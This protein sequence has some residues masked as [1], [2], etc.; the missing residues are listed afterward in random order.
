LL[1]PR[2]SERG[3]AE[4]RLGVGGEGAD[5]DL[6]GSGAELDRQLARREET[7]RQIRADLHGHHA[8][9][10]HVRQTQL[11]RTPRCAHDDARRELERRAV[12]DAAVHLEAD[13][14]FACGLGR[15]A[16]E[17]HLACSASRRARGGPVSRQ[18]HARD[19][20][21]HG[22]RVGHARPREAPFDPVRAWLDPDH[23][24]LA[25]REHHGRAAVDPNVDRPVPTAT[26]QRLRDAV[27]ARDLEA[28][29][30]T[31]GTD[32]EGEISGPHAHGL[33]TATREGIRVV[34]ERTITH[35]ALVRRALERP[36][37][38]GPQRRR[39]VGLGH[40]LRT[41]GQRVE[42]E[43]EQRGRERSGEQRREDAVRGAHEHGADGT[44]L[45]PRRRHAPRCLDDSF[46][47]GRA[48]RSR[49]IRDRRGRAA[50]GPHGR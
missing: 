41:S 36:R 33:G 40:R 43:D 21:G 10:Q 37:D 17:P 27:I 38:P 44:R 30:P 28:E 16:T 18:R 35:G 11:A 48:W 25:A 8:L 50:C 19:G 14:F 9:G 42:L 15:G 46:T 6:E 26:R 24:L 3:A 31:L 20:V 2:R 45:T 34:A 32:D 39:H 47:K 29:A 22:Q 4:D 5:G 7:H 13:L 23:G 49:W 1:G 12:L